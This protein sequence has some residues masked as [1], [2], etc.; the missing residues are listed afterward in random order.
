MFQDT[1]FFLLV[2]EKNIG[3]PRTVLLCLGQ[4]FL[5]SSDGTQQQFISITIN[6]VILGKNCELQPRVII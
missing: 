6:E 5:K 3:N 2:G 1:R 4:V